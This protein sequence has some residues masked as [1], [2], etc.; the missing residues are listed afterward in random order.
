MLFRSVEYYNGSGWNQLQESGGSTVYNSAVQ[1]SNAAW[2]LGDY[3]VTQSQGAPYVEISSAGT[4]STTGPST[5]LPG[6]AS[7]PNLPALPWASGQPALSTSA[8]TLQEGFALS[9]NGAGQFATVP[10]GK[11]SDNAGS[12]L[13]QAP[14]IWEPQVQLNN[15]DVREVFNNYLYNWTSIPFAATDGRQNLAFAVTGASQPINQIQPVYQLT[16]TPGLQVQQQL[17]PLQVE[18]TVYTTTTVPLV[19]LGSAPVASG[20]PQAFASLRG[21]SLTLTS[22]G[23]GASNQLAG[24]LAASG[25]ASA[26]IGR[27]HV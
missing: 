16:E 13:V 9:L 24:T 7:L 12:F 2:A 14:A 27:A 23:S 20:Q 11:P 1:W 3:T 25:S 4:W 17:L 8:G 15:G 22:T 6:I 21:R 19:G 26:K 5:T 18:Q 10:V